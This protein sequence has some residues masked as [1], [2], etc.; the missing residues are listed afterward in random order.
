M[1]YIYEVSFNLSPGQLEELKIG[2][3]LEKV[4]GYMRV[5]LPNQPGFVSTIAL[6]EVNS[7]GRPN[8]IFLSEWESW[9]DLLAHSQSSLTENKILLEFDPHIEK[10][11]LVRRIYREIE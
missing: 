11:H 8:L 3:S 9:E 2:R 5:L 4:I 1:A 7:D 6:Q 10:E